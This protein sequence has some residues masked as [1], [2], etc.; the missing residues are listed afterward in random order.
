MPNEESVQV[1][2]RCRW[3]GKLYTPKADHQ[4]YC[5]G[6]CRSDQFNMTITAKRKIRRLAKLSQKELNLANFSKI[7]DAKILMFKDK[8]LRCPCDAK[9]R[10]R[11]CGSKK[12][13]KEI[14][15]VG[16]CHCGLFKEKKSE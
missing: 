8:Y 2:R 5:C 1:K 12:C 11:Y 4:K 15:E 13:L 7:I 9:D 14:E 16:Q 3:C 6:K 10:M